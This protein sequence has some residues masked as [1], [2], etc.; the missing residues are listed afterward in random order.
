MNQSRSHI[1]A[2][3]LRRQA[4][5]VESRSLD[6]TAG[7]KEEFQKLNEQLGSFQLAVLNVR[8][9][10]EQLL[11]SVDGQCFCSRCEVIR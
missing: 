5:W 4:R 10:V 3:M 9:G 2:G 1:S 6:G 7:Q 8:N 11:A